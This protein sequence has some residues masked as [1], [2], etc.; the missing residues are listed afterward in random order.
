MKPIALATVAL[1]FAL[2][3]ANPIAAQQVR[4]ETR[5]TF[6]VLS[7][8]WDSLI[9]GALK[10]SDDEAAGFWPLYKE[11]KKAKGELWRKRIDLAKIYLGS[12]HDMTPE[13]ARILL[14]QSFDIDKD[15][16]DLEMSWA[17]RFDKVLPPNK[18]VR[19]YQAENK[20]EA[21]MMMEI[22]RDVPLAK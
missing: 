22:V 11:Y 17:P 6:E 12:Y 19:L 16:L 10:L 7:A 20:L 9:G 4:D 15:M 5:L 21:T 2:A 8:D 14:D 18:V 13:M 1:A 3:I